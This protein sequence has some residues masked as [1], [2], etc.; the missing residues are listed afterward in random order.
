MRGVIYFSPL[1]TR[2][3]AAYSSKKLGIILDVFRNS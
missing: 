1:A 3:M 2:E